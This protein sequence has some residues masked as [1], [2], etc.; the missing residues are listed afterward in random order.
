[1][2]IIPFTLPPDTFRLVSACSTA[3][4]IWVRLKEL[5]SID[6]DLE[7]LIQTLLLSDFGDFKQK[8]EENP[9]Q[10]FDHFNH[11]LSKMIKHGIGREVV[12]QRS[13]L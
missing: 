8:L 4:E 9:I 13:H 6:E 7:N 1:M 3:K 2:R 5:Y 10:M 12:E 11:L